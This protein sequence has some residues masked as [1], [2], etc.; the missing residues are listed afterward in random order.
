MKKFFLYFFGIIFVFLVGLMLYLAKFADEPLDDFSDLEP[1][2]T[3]VPAEEN[4][5]PLL[6]AELKTLEA[7]PEYDELISGTGTKADKLPLFEKLYKSNPKP[8][9]LLSQAIATKRRKIKL[10]QK[11]SI[12]KAFQSAASEAT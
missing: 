1:K 6:I 7:L 2:M 11:I 10:D 4:G 3:E 9:D 8:F 5:F 12:P